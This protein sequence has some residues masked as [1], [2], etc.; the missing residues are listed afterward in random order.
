M[1]PADTG[2]AYSLMC[3]NLDEF[4]VPAVVDYFLMQWP[5]GQIVACEATG[6]IIG[7]LA[8]AKLDGGRSSVSLLCVDLAYRNRGIGSSLLNSFLRSARMEGIR[9]VQ[10]E[11]RDTN[12]GAIRFY[13]RRGFMVTEELPGFYNNG[14][15]GIRMV[16]LTGPS[17]WS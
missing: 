4:F 12:V 15:N 7:Y 14:G 17:S 11:V 8:G 6:N 1:R 3:R 16:L 13:E 10:L 2:S 9:S 5:S